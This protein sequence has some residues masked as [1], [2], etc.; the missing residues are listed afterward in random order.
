MNRMDTIM[1]LKSDKSKKEVRKVPSL[2]RM[3]QFWTSAGS[4]PIVATLSGFAGQLPNE[5]LGRERRD[6]KMVRT[7][8]IIAAPEYEA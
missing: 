8:N 6:D 3:I 5:V 1:W 2:G 7:G 4:G